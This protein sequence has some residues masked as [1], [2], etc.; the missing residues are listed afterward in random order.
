MNLL[1]PPV[2]GPYESLDGAI[3]SLNVW[4]ALQG[5]AIVKSHT[6]TYKGQ[7]YRAYIGCDRRGRPRTTPVEPRR[8]GASRATGCPFSGLFCYE[9]GLWSLELR[10]VTHNHPPSDAIAHPTHGRLP[11]DALGY[12]ASLSSSSAPPG[13]LSQAYG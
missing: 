3:A 7:P 8:Q 13:R 5:Y 2:Q 6:K 9:E 12:I 4:A 1:P 10:V 11:P